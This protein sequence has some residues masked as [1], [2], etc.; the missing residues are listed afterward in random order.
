MVIKV[1]DQSWMNGTDRTDNKST[2]GVIK[3]RDLMIA[4][5]N[6]NSSLLQKK[7]KA[8]QDAMDIIK[9]VFARQSAEDDEISARHK[10]IEAQRA[11]KLEAVNQMKEMSDAK[12]GL[13]DK[14]SLTEGELDEIQQVQKGE[15]G[16][17]NLT[18]EQKQY[19]EE[20]AHYDDVIDHY[21]QQIKDIDG[22]I[23][24]DQGTVKGIK[25]ARL[26]EHEMVDAQKTADS[27]KEQASKEYIS[28][29]IKQAVDEVNDK[30]EEAQKAAEEKKEEKDKAEEKKEEKKA[31]K[32]ELEDR[33]EDHKEDTVTAE[34]VSN[35]TKVDD[36]M[37]QVRKA[38]N[39]IANQQSLTEDELKGIQVDEII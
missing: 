16:A 14:Y 7:K 4:V 13:A 24:E 8:G 20:A 36:S 18:T 17:E 32:E 5:Q 30:A 2:K 9:D 12:A 34:Q 19:M 37:T 10:D 11:Q 23:S 3:A 1:G 26:K 38:I 25:D 29:M 15:A 28:G 39:D 33:I 27:I 6:N 22:K 21:Q 35:N 31:E